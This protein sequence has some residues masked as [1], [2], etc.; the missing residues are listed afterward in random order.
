MRQPPAYSFLKA[1]GYSI[2]ASSLLILSKSMKQHACRKIRHGAPAHRLLYPRSRTLSLRRRSR[3]PRRPMPRRPR[4]MRGR[5][6]T[7]T[8]ATARTTSRSR[9]LQR[10][11]RRPRR[12]RPRRIR[13]RPRG[14][15]PPQPRRPPARSAPSESRRGGVQS[16]QHHHPPQ[17]PWWRER[18]RRTRRYRPPRSLPPPLP[19]CSFPHQRFRLARKIRSHRRR[20]R[21]RG[22]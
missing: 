12:R 17:L 2:G 16:D 9:F 10:R 8:A 11:S 22:R 5:W 19:P 4:R 21:A 13:P 20:R 3:R 7:S 6:C 1:W 15:L 14:H 18:H